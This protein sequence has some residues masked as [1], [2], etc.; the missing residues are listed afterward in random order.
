MGAVVSLATAPMAM[1]ATCCGS[2][3]G[4]CAASM[5]CK[6]CSCYCVAS[7][8]IASGF[9]FGVLMF[10]AFFAMLLR[11]DGGDIVLGGDYNSTVSDSIINHAAHMGT[12]GAL[13]YWNS[14]TECAPAHKSGLIICCATRCAGVFAVYRFS[15]TLCLFFAF[16]TCVP[17]PPPLV[18]PYAPPCPSRKFKTSSQHERKAKA[19]APPVSR[20]RV[21]YL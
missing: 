5:L 1:A 8:R 6:A 2:V 14:R 12:A 18:P 21:R 3:L 19:G 10:F 7:P 17:L 9:Y 15:F 16:L 11:F 13:E 20:P 4:S